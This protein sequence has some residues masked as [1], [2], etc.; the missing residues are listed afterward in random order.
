MRQLL[1]LRTHSH[2]Q[3]AAADA[4]VPAWGQPWQPA[5]SSLFLSAPNV[6]DLRRS[7]RGLHA[8][9]ARRAAR[10]LT[11]GAGAVRRCSCWPSAS[12]TRSL[13]DTTS[14]TA[15]SSEPRSALQ[16]VACCR[17]EL[18]RLAGNLAG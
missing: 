17:H 16:L 9:F 12:P 2:L 14:A 7:L 8:L 15:R 10:W 5:P 6:C 3:A 11:W 18:L 13:W 1:Q 4:P